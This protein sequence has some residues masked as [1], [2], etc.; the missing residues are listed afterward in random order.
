MTST[1]YLD[2]RPPAVAGTFY[3]SGRRTLLQ[4]LA[5]AFADANE[6]SPEAAVPKALI[7]PHAG[8]IYSGPIAASAY[9]RLRPARHAISRVVLVGPS[10]RVPLLGMAV[11]GARAFATP[12]GE[13]SIEDSARRTA[14][15]H[16]GVV[17]DD[18]AH[19]AEHSLEVQLPFLQY[20]LDTFEI[21]PIVVGHC[22]KGQVAAVLDALWGGPETVVVVSTDLSHYLRYAD[23]R[24]VDAATAEAV[25]HGR[26]ESIRG[27]DACGAVG[28]RGLLEEVRARGMS[29]QQL[30]LRN[31]GDTA[32]SHDSVVGYGAFAV[33]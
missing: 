11:S 16:D 30:D 14:L 24:H 15:A 10:H 29:V 9:G 4:A 26:V 6:V 3:P 25:V 28:L 31:S 27:E 8:Y 33:V 12:L 20:V 1:R 32:G 17:V 23:A 2:V 18:L 13:V 5:N 21:L 7:V 22:P 19:S